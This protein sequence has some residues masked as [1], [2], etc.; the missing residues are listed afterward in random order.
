M[1]IPKIE[2]FKPDEQKVFREIVEREQK[3]GNDVTEEDVMRRFWLETREAG[4]DEG[5]N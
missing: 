4:N 5:V 1:Y 2:D 3:K